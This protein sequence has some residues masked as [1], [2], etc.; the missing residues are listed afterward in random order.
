MKHSADKKI[1]GGE[2][3]PFYFVYFPWIPTI[4]CAHLKRTFIQNKWSISFFKVFDL[5]TKINTSQSSAAIT[6]K[7]TIEEKV[8]LFEKVIKKVY[9]ACARRTDGPN[10]IVD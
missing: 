2:Y 6:S 7:D 4:K 10:L 1:C 3:T 9:T 5:L 8:Q